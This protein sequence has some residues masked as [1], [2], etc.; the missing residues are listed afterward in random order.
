MSIYLARF[1]ETVTQ[2]MPT[3]WLLS[4]STWKL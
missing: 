1:R 3:L 2:Q 4:T